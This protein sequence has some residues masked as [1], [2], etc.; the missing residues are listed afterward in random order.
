[1]ASGD[2]ME[3][4]KAAL[5]PALKDGRAMVAWIAETGAKDMAAV[6]AVSVPALNALALVSGGM[7]M[8][9]SALAAQNL[10]AQ[11][12]GHADFLSTKLIHARFFAEQLLPHAS[13]YALSA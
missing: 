11:G 9:R 10:L 5:S 8:A 12:G 6:S 7:M 3:A 2:D 1:A 13:V 4:I